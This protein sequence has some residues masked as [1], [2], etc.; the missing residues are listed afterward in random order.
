[1]LAIVEMSQMQVYGRTIGQRCSYVWQSMIYTLLFYAVLLLSDGKLASVF[2]LDSYFVLW[3]GLMLSDGTLASAFNLDI[4][5]VLWA[6]VLQ[7]NRVQRLHD[8]LFG[9]L[10]DHVSGIGA[11]A[12]R[13]VRRGSGDKDGDQSD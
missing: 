3:A 9:W 4:Y 12:H 5:F 1:M 6:V 8:K 13:K 10:H 11:A 7:V 2:N